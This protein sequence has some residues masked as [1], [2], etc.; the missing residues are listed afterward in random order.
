M[1]LIERIFADYFISYILLYLCHLLSLCDNYE[2]SISNSQFFTLPLITSPSAMP[3]FT[4]MLMPS[5]MPMVI[6]LRSNF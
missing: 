5:E 2:F 3:L 1:T 4:S 6:C